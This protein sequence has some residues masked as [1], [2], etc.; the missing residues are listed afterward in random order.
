MAE[1]A[2]RIRQL[3]DARAILQA[4]ISNEPHRL[5][6]EGLLSVKYGQEIQRDAT[7]NGEEEEVQDSL[8]T[9]TI[10]VHGEAKYF[11]AGSEVGSCN[12]A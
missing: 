12:A 9:L 11:G 4:E 10:N 3:E 2:Q 5:L 7:E 1:M 8:G 6:R